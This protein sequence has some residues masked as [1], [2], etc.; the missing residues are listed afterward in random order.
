MKVDLFIPCFIDQLYPSTAF[1][2]EKLLRRCGVQVRYNPQQTCC[3]QPAFNSGYWKE[4]RSLASKFLD[5]FD[6]AELIVSPSASCASYARN[7]YHRLFDGDPQKT[8]Q[9]NSLK[10]KIFELS[11]FLV[12]FL[13]QTDFGAKFL[14]RVTYHDACSAL[15]EYGIR[16]EPRQLLRQVEGLELA[17]MEDTETCCGFGGTFAAKFKD[18]STAMT[19]QKLENALATGAEFIVSTEASCLMNMESY[20]RKNKL[21]LRT[22]HLADVLTAGW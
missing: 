16:E 2:V 14:Y 6:E 22:I 10:P 21:P 13:H 15:R 19:Q 1:N 20:L 5:D 18:I 8:A 17:E 7:Y 3:G 9:W 4:A 12:N 11:D